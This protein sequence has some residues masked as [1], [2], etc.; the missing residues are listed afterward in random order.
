M[1]IVTDRKGVQLAVG[2]FSDREKALDWI[3][4]QA[5][6]NDVQLVIVQ[7]IPVRLTP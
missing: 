7:L 3:K 1:Y 2:P 4:N 5:V 6:S